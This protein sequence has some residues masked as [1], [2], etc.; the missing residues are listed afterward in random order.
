MLFTTDGKDDEQ[1]PLQT[2]VVVDA[3]KDESISY[4]L[5][6]LDAEYVCLFRKDEAERLASVAPY[7][8]ILKQGTK[9]TQWFIDKLYGNSLSFI[10]Q[11]SDP[12]NSLAAYFA[13]M[14]KTRL[15]DSKEQAYFRFYDPLVLNSYLE[16][17]AE[18]E[19]VSEFMGNAKR[20][21][22]EVGNGLEMNQYVKD[23]NTEEIAMDVISLDNQDVEAQ[24]A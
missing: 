23:E 9:V 3:A 13:D 12:I 8:L 1:L 18:E 4:Y 19:A 10:V 16:A 15:P 6:G 17:L 5:E 11:S 21:L 22:V 7:L 2:F 14:I 24:V 20:F